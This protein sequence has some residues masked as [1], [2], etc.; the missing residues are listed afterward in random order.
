MSGGSLDYVCY[1]LNDAIDIVESRAKTTLQKAFTT[2][3]R[4]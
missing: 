4:R 1:R 2:L 3:K